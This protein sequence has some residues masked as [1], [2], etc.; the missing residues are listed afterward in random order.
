[1]TSRRHSATR[2]RSS[3]AGTLSPTSRIPT[4]PRTSTPPRHRRRARRIHR[5]HV[6]FLSFLSARLGAWNSYLRY[7][8]EAESCARVDASGHFPLRSHLRSAD[9]ARLHRRSSRS[10][11]VRC[12]AVG[13]NSWLRC[14]GRCRGSD[15]HAAL[16]PETPTGRSGDRPRARRSAAAVRVRSEIPPAHPAPLIRADVS[17]RPSHRS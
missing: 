11:K 6:V 3:I 4:G 17:C 10:G 14:T 1:M 9:P 12:L 8:T 13:P 15:L 2:T 5:P 7:K 16:D